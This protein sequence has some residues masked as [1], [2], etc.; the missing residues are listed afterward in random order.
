[1]ATNPWVKSTF[2]AN[3]FPIYVTLLLLVTAAAMWTVPETKGRILDDD[4]AKYL[5]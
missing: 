4:D 3:A 2:G 1:M 5:G